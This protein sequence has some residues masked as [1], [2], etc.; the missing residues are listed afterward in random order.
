MKVVSSPYA[1]LEILTKNLDDRAWRLEERKTL[2]L[3][4][5]KRTGEFSDRDGHVH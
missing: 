1:K 4:L 5:E 2:S 3:V